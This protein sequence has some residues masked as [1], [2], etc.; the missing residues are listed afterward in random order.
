M[1]FFRDTW[2][3]NFTND[4]QYVEMSHFNLFKLKQEHATYYISEDI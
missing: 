4:N 1:F 3:V 2:L